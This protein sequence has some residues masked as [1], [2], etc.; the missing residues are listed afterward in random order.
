MIIIE[1]TRQQRLKHNYKRDYFRSQGI[2]VRK[3]TLSCG[4]YT[5][6]NDRSIVI[7]TKKDIQELIGDIQVKQAPLKEITPAVEAIFEKYKI[8]G[9]LP[10]TIIRMIYDSDEGRYPERDILEICN[11]FEIDDDA[12][13]EFQKLYVKRRGFF[14][15]GLK[16]AEFGDVKLY[17]LVENQGGLVNGT[18][19]IFNKTVRNID[20]LFSWKNPR[21]FIRIGGRQ[22]YPNA[23]KGETLAK[24]CLTMQKKYGMEF[25]FCPPQDSGRKIIELL[26]G[27]KP[28]G[29]IQKC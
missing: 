6:I 3:E 13:K 27:A 9:L 20:D 5:L 18:R 10:E 15:R 22:K 17:V 2:I 25:L 21:L 28:N 12:E 19:D 29:D 11:K 24:A 16:R 1:D 4:D 23:M 7:D 14:H 8:K 26:G